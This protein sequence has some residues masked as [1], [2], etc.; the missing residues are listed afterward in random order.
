[1]LLHT[2]L[3]HF[4]IITCHI[5]TDSS[6]NTKS[7]YTNGVPQLLHS[8]L[9]S[10]NTALWIQ[11]TY[12]HPPTIRE[13]IFS[14]LLAHQ[15]IY[16]YSFLHIPDGCPELATSYSFPNKSALPSVKTQVV[17]AP[18]KIIDPYQTALRRNYY[19]PLLSTMTVETIDD[20]NIDSAMA[21]PTSREPSPSSKEKTI[22]TVE[23]SLETITDVLAEMDEDDPPVG[24]QLS[25]E[26]P[27]GQQQVI[28]EK[29]TCFKHRFSIYRRSALTNIPAKPPTQLALFRSFAKALQSIDSQVQILPM[30]NDINIHPLSTTDQ[31]NHID[32]IG[33]PNYFKAY[34]KTKRTLSGDF[35]IGT[36]LP[37]DDLKQHQNLTTWFLHHGYN[38]ALSRCQSSDMVCIGF[39]SRVRGFTYRD[40]LYQHIIAQEKWINQ[41]FHFRL[42]F[43]SFST[44]VKALTTYVLM[45]DV[46]RP[47]IK[48]AMSFF[49]EMYDGDSLNSPNK[50]SYLF[51]P[52]Y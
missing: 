23:S 37:F 26:Q 1:M 51:L 46:D 18:N 32:E 24:T 7:C 17:T 33:I 29:P 42:Y 36:K 31:L 5:S 11:L 45:I 43:D 30:R 16:Y 38:I 20:N 39:L 8:K 6:T 10:L 47:N 27:T 50:I 25:Q 34:K 49:Q 9:L 21:T 28:K 14:I 13:L 44:N 19:H 52:L 41:P 3:S 40:D 15:K 12:P 2:I 22:I 48:I 35:H 4:N